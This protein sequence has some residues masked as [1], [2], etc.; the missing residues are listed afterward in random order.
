MLTSLAHGGGVRQQESLDMLAVPLNAS[1]SSASSSSLNRPI[2]T[3]LP[4]RREKTN[5]DNGQRTS[6][7]TM[8]FSNSLPDNIDSLQ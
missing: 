7:N 6:G 2:V 5:A 3:V 4:Y 8:H 1:T